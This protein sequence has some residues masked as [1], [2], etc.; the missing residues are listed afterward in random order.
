MALRNSRIFHEKKITNACKTDARCFWKFV[1]ASLANRP[2]V[3]QVVTPSGDLSQS[4]FDTAECLNNF[5][6][7]IFTREVDD[8]P[9]FPLRTTAELCSVNISFDDVAKVIRSLPCKSAPGP[10]GITYQMIKEGG[11]T[12]IDILTRFFV[13]LMDTGKL[14]LEWKLAYVV[15]I[16]KKGSRA[17]CE[18]YRPISLTCVV[19][20][21]LE[22]ILKKAILNFFLD[23][24]LLNFS[25]HG[26]LPQRSSLTALLVF[27]DDVSLSIDEGKCTDA[28]YLD[29]SKA[30]DSV[31]HQYLINKLKSYG[32]GKPLITWLSAFL[33]GRQQIVKVGSSFSRRAEVLSGVPQGS[34]LGPLLFLIYINDIDDS[35]FE[36]SLIKFADDIRLYLSFPNLRSVVHGPNLL[37]NDLSRVLSWCKTWLLKLNV[38]KCNCIRFGSSNPSFPYTLDSTSLGFVKEVVDLGVTVSSDLKPSLHCLRAATKANKVLGCIKLAFRFLDAST[39]V[40]LYKALVL[41]LLDYCS[42]A[43]SPLYVKDIE[44]LEKVQRRMTRFL[45]GLRH[46]SYL[47]RLRSLGLITLH[48]RRLRQDM[49]FVYKL[50]HGFVGLDTSKFFVRAHDSRTRGH[51]MKL[52]IGYSRLLLRRATFS[53]RIV[54]L[55]NDLPSNCVDASSLAIFKSALALYFEQNGFH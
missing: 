44:V 4:D 10:D 55:W 20:K 21:I 14:P 28:I 17:R 15:P 32:I 40:T 31:P 30:F 9:P 6:S 42:V 50:L 45:P 37:Q 33:N 1:R 11:L 26:F 39:L 29:F 7:S 49:I 43:W 16:F 27:L 19:C 41:P 12:L 53:Q 23:N 47:D 25:Q 52:Q 2:C 38:S 46:L 22:V 35:V 34:I 3:S 24:Q 5:F 13:I 8:D 48:T 18:N 54:S 51:A 36:S